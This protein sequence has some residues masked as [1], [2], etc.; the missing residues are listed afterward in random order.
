[1]AEVVFKSSMGRVRSQIWMKA[2]ADA[3]E[4]GDVV[5]DREMRIKRAT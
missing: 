4:V 5:S 2:E 3:K 1:M